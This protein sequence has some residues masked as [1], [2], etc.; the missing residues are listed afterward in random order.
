[1]NIDS[2][3]TRVT[4]IAM[5]MRTA[6]RIACL[7]A[8][9]SSAVALHAPR[10]SPAS[11]GRLSTAAPR[12]SLP[13]AP[14]PSAAVP[15]GDALRLKGGA[16]ANTL[17]FSLFKAIVGSGVL[18]LS[19][20]MAAFTNSRA[21]LLPSFALA[22]VSMILSAYSYY[23][24]GAT[25][26]ATGATTYKEAWSA[27]VGPST[28]WV[29]SLAIVSQTAV[30]TI[31]YAI[32]IGDVL[33]DV[34][35]AFGA[36]GA[37]A[38]RDVLLPSIAALVILPLCM[39]RDFGLLAYTSM[40]GVAGVLYC[41]LFMLYRHFSGSYSRGTELFRSLSAAQRPSFGSSTTPLK[42]LILV[43][44][45]NTA[46]MAHYDAPKFLAMV[47]NRLTEFA[48]LTKAGFFGAFLIS[49]L[50]MASGFLTFGGSSMGLILNNY[51]A[52]D[53]L[54]LLARVGML[55]SIVFGFPLVFSGFRTGALS[56]LDIKAPSQATLD[57][58]AV[59]TVSVAVGVALKMSDLGFAASFSGALLGSAIIYIFPAMMHV[60]LAKKAVEADQQLK[61]KKRKGVALG[62]EAYMN[63]GI[64]ALGVALA[65]IG[66][67]VSYLQSFTDILN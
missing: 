40:F 11:L 12:S 5:R 14:N 30:A 24:V 55:A 25:C 46:Y 45:F 64:M 2:L 33:R 43:A 22:F 47:G 60:A 49:A 20:G 61:P 28:A 65:G 31:C 13:L 63:Y 59:A 36:T 15:R 58:I 34:A 29:P 35:I 48:K 53:T 41:T 6:V 42:A 9:A 54:A 51:A 16:D 4:Y 39:L 57:T 32:I 18:C 37:L 7:A 19:G 26:A 50:I 44:M 17:V 52:G 67:S 27:T 23:S 56:L 10:A 8:A 3:R 66:A 38:N 62:N 1:M 21:M